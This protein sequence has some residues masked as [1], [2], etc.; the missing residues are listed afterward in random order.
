MFD[1]LLH[2]GTLDCY[3][4]VAALSVKPTVALAIYNLILIA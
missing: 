3:A 2:K 1:S 4:T